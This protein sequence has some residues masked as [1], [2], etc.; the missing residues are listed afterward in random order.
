MSKRSKESLKKKNGI[1]EDEV[2]ELNYIVGSP[3]FGIKQ[4]KEAKKDELKQ[5]AL[6]K[7]KYD[8]SSRQPVNEI[9]KSYKKLKK[10]IKECNYFI[11][12]KETGQIIAL[13][14]SRLNYYR[15]LIHDPDTVSDDD[16]NVMVQF[17]ENWLLQQGEFDSINITVPSQ[18]FKYYVERE[19]IQKYSRRCYILHFRN[20]SSGSLDKK[21]LAELEIRNLKGHLNRKKLKKISD[22][23]NISLNDSYDMK[24]GF[25]KITTFDQTL[26]EL[27]DL[28]G[29]IIQNSSFIA[30][31]KLPDGSVQNAGICLITRWEGTYLVYMV[32]VFPRFRGK[33]LATCLIQ[34]SIDSLGYAGVKELFLFVTQGNKIAQHIYVNKFGFEAVYDFA[35]FTKRITTREI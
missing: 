22:L 20:Q 26:K 33:G 18:W 31:K 6:F 32:A 28:K 34:H 12:K 16:M 3:S 7:E 2:L 10:E 21:R 30:T 5:I 27:K 4:W 1:P 13:M 25:I 24:A 15:V 14:Y 29:D 19:Y 8:R 11:Q 35:N 23:L 9:I 17:L